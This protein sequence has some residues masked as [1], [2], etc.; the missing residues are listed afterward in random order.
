MGSV[1]SVGSVGGSGLVA[2]VADVADDWQRIFNG[3]SGWWECGECGSRQAPG[4]ISMKVR[5]RLAPWA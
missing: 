2:D 3:C 1:G 5:C 4:S